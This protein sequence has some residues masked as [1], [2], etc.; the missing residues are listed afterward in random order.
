MSRKT[1]QTPG[2][3][4]SAHRQRRDNV[5]WKILSLMLAVLLIVT[6]V[7]CGYGWY[8]VKQQ[9]KQLQE[10]TADNQPMTITPIT[11]ELSLFSL[12]A[13]PLAAE[14][15]DGGTVTTSSSY[16]LTAKISPDTSDEKE[17]DWTAA[18]QNAAGDWSTGKT[19][20]DFVKLTPS[21]NTLSVTAECLEAFAEP[22]IITAAVHGN[23]TVKATCRA[24]YLQKFVGVDLSVNYGLEN[25]EITSSE[26]QS[27][28]DEFGAY[29]LHCNFSY[30][31]TNPK[32]D[33]FRPELMIAP[34]SIRFRDLYKVPATVRYIAHG[35]EVYT[36]AQTF[37]FSSFVVSVTDTYKTAIRS[38]GF[39]V[40]AIQGRVIVYLDKLVPGYLL[41]NSQ[42]EAMQPLP[43]E[44]LNVL[45][46]MLRQA[47]QSS[48]A[49]T[50]LIVN[51]VG[52]LDGKEYNTEYNIGFTTD[53]LFTPASDVVI[54]PP[55]VIY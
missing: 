16:T 51:V 45:R 36:I 35:S 30:T 48:N 55:K 8:R 18:F 28:Y 21:E 7:F 4:T 37:D 46:Q 31:D 14:A 15:T 10:L 20:T 17:I 12:E 19:A 40:P 52:S 1:H 29:E 34:N 49:F 42:Y 44:F 22:I 43:I 39:N 53:S 6:S 9:K 23:E 3:G 27:A 41:L 33:F 47:A 13:T 24:D 50:Q 25:I 26:Q 54:D 38:T 2:R 5:G 11:D 32:I